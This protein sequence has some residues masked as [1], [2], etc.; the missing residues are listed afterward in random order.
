VL[1]S[2]YPDQEGNKLGS[3]SGTRAISTTSRRE[4]SSCSFLQGKAPKEIH[5]ILIETLTCFL[6][7]RAKDLSA[8][9]YSRWSWWPNK[10][11]LVW[12]VTCIV[13]RV[14]KN[15]RNTMCKISRKESFEDVNKNPTRCNSMQ[16]FILL[17]SHCT[18]FGCHSTHHQEY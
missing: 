9:L 5:V 8:P 2:P 13:Y 15:T 4:M 11:G 3:M 17:Q 12:H 1:I 7:G 16:I 10:I 6:P 14:D 18:C